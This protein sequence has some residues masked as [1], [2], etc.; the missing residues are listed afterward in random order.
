[1]R[2]PLSIVIAIIVCAAA[3]TAAW[4]VWPHVRGLRPALLSSPREAS[5]PAAAITPAVS[6]AEPRTPPSDGEAPSR[7]TTGFPLVLAPG[8]SIGTYAT[9]LGKPRVLLM[10]GRG[11]L[12]VSVPSSGK[13]L[14]LP[15]RDRDGVA[16]ETRTVVDGLDRPHGLALRTT[17]GW[18]LSIAETG[19]VASYAYDPEA[20]R[21]TNRRK[22]F[23]LP[24]GGGHFTRTLLV[25]RADDGEERLLVSVGSSCNACAERDA[26]RATVLSARLDGSDLRTFARGLRNAVF[27]A[28]HPTTGAVWVTEMGR[29]L[30]GDD[31]PPDE[32]N[33]LQEG[34]DY[35][36]PYCYGK[37]VRDPFNSRGR[38]NC[39]EKMTSHVDLPAH[40]APLGLAFV[41]QDGWPAAWQG[42]LLVAFHG[43]WNRTEPTGYKI[44]RFDLDATG[45]PV[46]AP[47]DVISGWLSADDR[48]YGRPVDLLFAPDGA[49]YISDDKAGVV[50]RVMYDGAR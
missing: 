46:G 38:V 8:L 26:R 11:T 5:R 27:L 36:W 10:D 13:V 29:D 47:Q 33:I 4:R 49:L 2:R 43:S 25:A 30:L 41:P 40:S 3:V 24:A 18:Q 45:A 48:A 39:S 22:L 14:A 21:A 1:M 19:A 6:D 31:L 23:D 32:I 35:G 16:D 12:L 17:D 34:A 50:Y 42:D 9:G 20:M 37:N 7:N 28:T 44:V 15:D